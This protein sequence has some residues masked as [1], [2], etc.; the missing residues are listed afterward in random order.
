MANSRFGEKEGGERD[1]AEDGP[2]PPGLV[3]SSGP[4]PNKL[5]K[6]FLCLDPCSERCDDCGL[7]F[8]CCKEHFRLHK[9]PEVRSFIF[10]SCRTSSSYSSSNRKSNSSNN[11]KKS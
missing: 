11:I 3:I 2:P 8:Y 6:C 5:G 1:E 4:R 10:S 7:I 9:H